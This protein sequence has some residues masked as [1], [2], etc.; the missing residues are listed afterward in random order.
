MSHRLI[1]CGCLA[2]SAFIVCDEGAAASPVQSPGS[3]ARLITGFC[4]DCHT[5]ADAEAGVDLEA[6]SQDPI[7]AEFASWRKIARVVADGSM[8][9]RDAEQPAPS[10][11]KSVVDDLRRAIQATQQRAAKDPGPTVVRRLTNAEYDYCIEDLTG[12]R[13]DLRD[14]LIRDGV[15]GSGFINASTGQ[16]VQ[17][18]T[19]ERY[20]EAARHVASHAM[21]GAGPL[22]F[23]EAP[24]RTGLELSSINRLQAFYRQ[25]GFRAS[26]GEGAKPYGMERF[27]TA[28]KVAWI[29][30][31]RQTLGRGDVTLED[32]AGRS[33][34]E[35]RF[36]RHIYQVM[37]RQDAGYPLSK[38]IEAWN[39]FPTPA[40]IEGDVEQ[41]IQN[42]SRDL[43]EQLERWQSRFASTASSEEEAA[44]LTGAKI[45]VP[46]SA[47]FQARARRRLRVANL[48]DFTIDLDDPNLYS[49]D[50]RVRFKV[51]V[52]PAAERAG[53][54]PAVIFSDAEAEFSYIDRIERDPVPL[55]SVLSEEQL[56][57]LRFGVNADGE[58]I[59]AT[60]FVVRSGQSRTI[61]FDL[62]DNSRSVEILVRAR[63]D[64]KLSRDS[65]VR[66]SIEDLTNDRGRSY[67]TLLRDRDSR[68]IDRW[69]AGLQEF[70]AAL[71]Q[72]SHREPA[73]SDRDPI[74]APY[75]NAYNLP[76]RNYFHTAIKYHR[77]DR[78]LTRHLLSDAAAAELEIAWTDL[79]TS[80][81][82]HDVN[83][84]FVT[85]KHGIEIGDRTIDSID[86]DW[87]GTLP[88]ETRRHVVRYKQEYDAM[89]AALR[90]AESRHGRD[91]QAFA[92][93]CWRRPLIETERQRLTEFYESCRGSQNMDHPSAVRATIVRIL[94]SPQFLYRLE[95]PPS[96]Q[97]PRPLSGTELATR[98]SFTFWSSVPDR[99]LSR[100]AA[101]DR[102]Q[103]T[104]VLERQVR[105][106]LASPKSR[107]FA[108]EFFGQW[109]GFYRFDQFR[110][111]DPHQ[112]PEFDEPLRDALYREAIAFFE[113]LVR[114]DR[115]YHE[116]LHADYTFLEPAT[117]RHYG[118]ES[119]LA[120]GDR[121]DATLP[122]RQRRVGS[123]GRGGLF[124]M[125]ALLASTSAPLR[126]SPV[127]RGD[128]ILRRLLGT[129][130]PPP[131]ADAGSIAAEEVSGDGKTVRERLE[132]HR[133]RAECNSCHVRIDPLG[134]ALENFDSLGRW[135]DE[136]RD[137]Q[138]IDPSGVLADG[139]QIR[140]VGGLKKYLLEQ[141][142]SFRRTFAARLVAY[143]LG[144]P[145]T[146][147]DAALIDSIATK[148]KADP[149]VSTAVTTLVLSPQFQS[150]R[151][152]DYR[153]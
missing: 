56:Q 116:V 109:L 64:A 79:L 95:E 47:L 30:R 1:A 5:G 17:D 148:L 46:S 152:K 71:P 101:E 54:D 113:H 3:F 85:K 39:G 110:G 15:G 98:L 68:S 2:L 90:S 134:F 20:L 132:V 59:Q 69:E 80:F 144:R 133:T 147:A 22:F 23:D 127:K 131:P 13:L 145:E 35:P 55:M 43:Y 114:Q 126:T 130:V 84:R 70:A 151:G 112:F 48:E 142:D 32:L 119:I 38:I 104:D 75:D 63:L 67:S 16:F 33:E 108:T 150:I 100:L 73:P 58:P 139:R 128:W 44:L 27:A 97:Q 25:H 77:D 106:M 102:L 143:A 81:D 124:G 107:R 83:F 29:Y 66:C 18:S 93:R 21:V 36:A 92:Q 45:E 118:L 28:F 82:Y 91:L 122:L 37:T 61:E 96:G 62:P 138:P 125:G 129:P 105:R 76:E 19:L 12:V 78:F 40:E 74:P 9:P 11:R 86:Q 51:S 117:A 136:Y 121:V 135:R 94:T 99:E 52:L 137:G 10:I 149:R 50:G 8:P 65:V 120:E 87:I 89:M 4:A 140:G 6:L 24:G 146:A 72:I 153:E 111:I 115:P 42:A 31:H 123:D 60:E 7:A 53:P 141:D 26:A 34:L 49:E 14:T 57:S 88:M 103:E 41:R